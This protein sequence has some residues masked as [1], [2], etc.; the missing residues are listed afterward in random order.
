MSECI[1]PGAV[2]LQQPTNAETPPPYSPPQH[3]TITPSPLNSPPE[4]NT[5][6][7]SPFQQPHPQHI[8]PMHSST[9]ANQTNP[10][11]SQ[12]SRSYQVI[13]QDPL[14]AVDMNE[15][16]NNQ[17]QHPYQSS[18]LDSPFNRFCCLSWFSCVLFFPV[19][20]MSVYFTSKARDAQLK[21]NTTETRNNRKNAVITAVAA[22][23]GF[24]MIMFAMGF[25]VQFLIGENEYGSDRH[26]PDSIYGRTDGARCIHAFLKTNN[27]TSKQR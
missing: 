7:P 17:Q 21:G 18:N 15:S 6:P 14:H 19:G 20:I 24:G 22:V 23:W 10:T 11:L 8:E 1:E 13:V 25:W 26:P 9:I 5:I 3:D 4:H 2:Q 27:S 16:L 12:Q